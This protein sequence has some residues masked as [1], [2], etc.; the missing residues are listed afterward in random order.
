M[1][2]FEEDDQGWS[3]VTSK[4]SARSKANKQVGS[5][6]PPTTGRPV[7]IEARRSDFRD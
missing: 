4:S 3:E 5:S 7:S 6:G 2:A 1:A